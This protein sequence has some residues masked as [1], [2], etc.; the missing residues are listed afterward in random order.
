MYAGRI[1]ETRTVKTTGNQGPGVVSVNKEKITSDSVS[2]TI[3][4]PTAP[5]A[6]AG[7]D[8]IVGEGTLVTL[9]GT[10]SSDP[11]G[12]LLFYSWMQIEGPVVTMSN[13]D[14]ANPTF[15]APMVDA[16]TVLTFHLVVNDD[17][18][19]SVPDVVNILVKDVRLAP[20]ATNEPPIA[21]DDAY[22]V[23][24]GGTINV[25]APGVLDGDTDADGDP[26]SAV[27]VSGPANAISFTLNSDGS[28]QYTHDGSDTLSDSFTYKANDG[29]L[30]SNIATVSID[31]NESPSDTCDPITNGLADTNLDGLKDT[32]FT[33]SEIF[34]DYNQDGKF[35][36]G[37]VD[38][39]K[40]GFYDK[41]WYDKNGDGM[42]AADKSEFKWFNLGQQSVLPV[43]SSPTC[44]EE[45]IIPPTP[46]VRDFDFDGDG[47]ADMRVID[48]DGDGF[49]ET[50]LYNND[51]DK[52]P[53]GSPDFDEGFNDTD[54]DGD[55][56]NIWIDR[57]DNGRVD[58][59]EAIT[60]PKIP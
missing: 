16:D 27:M 38:L 41:L 2:F 56:N 52:L 40:N 18:F 14:T 59:G 57:N 5:V 54:R 35:E 8:Q 4:S 36:A 60:I 45:Q 43:M 3:I 55:Y 11:D 1:I 47:I 44:I 29:T 13:P 17:S 23:D 48:A 15:D 24:K 20:L 7:T 39:D 30:D 31:V 12:D 53:D 21:N 50:I 22:S 42:V 19:D 34:F 28:F 26:L 58:L 49:F 51:S 37:L 33:S 46:P 32:Q 9:D 25:A 10:G 6:N